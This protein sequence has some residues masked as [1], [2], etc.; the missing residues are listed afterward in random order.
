MKNIFIVLLIVV[1]VGIGIYLFKNQTPTTDIKTDTTQ[2]EDQIKDTEDVI[3]DKES[4]IGKSVEGR[5]I[6]A[7]H[8]GTGET[9]LLFVGGIHGGY[10][11]NTVLLA[12]E[13]MDYLE[14]NPNAVPSEVKVT[15]IPVLN[16]DGLN[17]VAG[18]PGRFLESD[19]SS[20]QTVVV[21]G[22]FNANKVD[23]SRNFDCN[24][25]SSAVWQT[26]SVSGGSSVF[27]EPE[28]KAVRDYVQAHNIS[29]A[30]VWYSAAGGVYASSCNGEGVSTE[31]SAITNVY[32][33]ASGYPAHENFDFYET[34]GDMVDWLAKIDVPAISVLL[35]THEDVEWEKN[36]K[37]IE[38]FIEYYAK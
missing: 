11:W 19:I 17:K 26:R 2:L 6:T 32:A 28:S 21:S 24:W 35:S 1:F 23:L 38:A 15:V 22:R 9:E 27:S 18:T 25:K 37:G 3:Q 34:T 4:I 30:V 10:S 33:D 13:L 36:K 14:V 5:D 7:Y 12:Y 16:P 29:G 31:T 8:Y 20:S